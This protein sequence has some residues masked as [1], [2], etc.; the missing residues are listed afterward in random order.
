MIIE[1]IYS[2]KTHLSRLIEK[3]LE[4]EEVIIAKAG[5][6]LVRMIAFEPPLE[7]LSYGLLKGRVR[8]ADDFNDYSEEVA[9]MFAGYEPEEDA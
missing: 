7:P 9:D 3:V 4:G 5:K 2:A 1:N 6:P 8:I